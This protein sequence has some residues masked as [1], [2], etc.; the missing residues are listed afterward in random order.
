[1]Y[2]LVRGPLVW[3]AFFVFIVG[4]AYQIVRFRALSDKKPPT[5]RKRPAGAKKAEEQNFEYRF[6]MFKLTIAGVNPVTFVVTTV[7]H[8]CLVVTP[9]FVLG[10]N[11]LW[12]LTVGSSLPSFPEGFSDALAIIVVLCG[13][14]FLC[15]RLLLA[16]VRSITS[17]YDYVVLAIA[18]VPFVTGVMAYHQLGDYHTVMVIHMLSGEIMLMAIPFTKLIHMFYFFINRF[19]M[20]HENTFGRGGSR[21]WQ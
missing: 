8:V 16:R 17:F 3:V 9:F 7:F 13:V 18:I 2:D 5:R 1:M 20:I 19:T 14:Y 11:V 4:T 6:E 15:R 12:D 10:H 21:V